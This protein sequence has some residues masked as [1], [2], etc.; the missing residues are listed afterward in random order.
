MLQATLRTPR[1]H[2]AYAGISHMPNAFLL[3]SGLLVNQ[4]TDAIRTTNR[5]SVRLPPRLCAEDLGSMPG[6]FRRT[7]SFYNFREAINRFVIFLSL[8]FVSWSRVACVRPLSSQLGTQSN[9]LHRGK[10]SRHFTTLTCSTFE[11]LG[12]NG[13]S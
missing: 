3:P 5:R 12:W 6:S 7:F 10:R 11:R 9:D 13:T 4:K 1:L 2:P 8:I